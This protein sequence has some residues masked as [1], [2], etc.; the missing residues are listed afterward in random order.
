MSEAVPILTHDEAESVGRAL[1]DHLVNMTG[2]SPFRRDDL[3]LAD[4]V[5]FVTHKA[6]ELVAARQSAA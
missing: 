2:A 5:Q 4:T 3:G 1:H 6:R